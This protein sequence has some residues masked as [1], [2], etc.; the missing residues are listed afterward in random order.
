MQDFVANISI[1]LSGIQN[2]LTH[3]NVDIQYN[4]T[5]ITLSTILSTCNNL[6]DLTF[7][8]STELSTHV[9]NFASGFQEHQRLSNLELAAKSISG[10]DIEPI[11]RRSQQLRRLAINGGDIS[12]LDILIQ[13]MPSNI[14]TLGFNYSTQYLPPLEK[15]IEKRKEMGLLHLYIF[16]ST[17]PLC[18]MKMLQLLYKNKTTLETLYAN[19]QGAITKK[20]LAT[21]YTRYPDFNLEKIK[22]IK[23]DGSPWMIDEFLLQIIR[24]S[25]TLKKLILHGVSNME[26]LA[27]TLFEMP[28]LRCL[29]IWRSTT[30]TMTTVQP[31]NETIVETGGES[32]LIRL[33]EK[34]AQFS[35]TSTSLESLYLFSSYEGSDDMLKT[36]AQI[37]TLKEINLF[38][39]PSVSKSGIT[40]FFCKIGPQLTK[41]NLGILDCV[42]DSVFAVLGEH[43]K[44]L[45]ILHAN[46]LRNVTDQGV[47][48][49]VDKTS[50]TLTELNLVGCSTV[51]KDCVL[52][53][54]NK[55]KNVFYYTP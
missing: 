7:S 54:E 15:G 11:I 27:D 19:T 22:N 34:Y 2:T 14:E 24:Q 44:N 12:V 55:V 21:L 29:D 50:S 9:G 10:Q 38:E 36:L 52:D 51:T 23:Y 6:T 41:V 35:T 26:K 17:E 43:G 16:T 49:L 39:A 4:D 13:T 5:S 18:E 45:S 46:K 32:S 37:R 8:T 53:I 30:I 25:T 28:P 33:F 42:D 20:D 31:D 1:V 3:L 40:E 48:A 47:R